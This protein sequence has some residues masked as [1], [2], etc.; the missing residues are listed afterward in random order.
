MAPAIA[1]I[2]MAAVSSGAFHQ[3]IMAVHITANTTAASFCSVSRASSMVRPCE[4]TPGNSS[5]K[6]IYTR[7]AQV[8]GVVTGVVRKV[9]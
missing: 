3:H 9:A 2:T 8:I 6:P 4:L 1:R 7:N 5:M